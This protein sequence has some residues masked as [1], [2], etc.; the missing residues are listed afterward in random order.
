MM[1][2]LFMFFAF[3]ISPFTFAQNGAG[4]HS[5][6]MR[7]GTTAPDLP[8]HNLPRERPSTE[9][10][11]DEDGLKLKINESKMKVKK[12]PKANESET[13]VIQE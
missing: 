9:E 10:N 6:E 12:L 1:K 11:I 8:S 13:K 2:K 5:V 4:P 7:P 3:L